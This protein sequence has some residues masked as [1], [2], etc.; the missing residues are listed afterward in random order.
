MSE[1]QKSYMWMGGDVRRQ[2]MSEGRRPWAE[3]LPLYNAARSRDNADE[4]PRRSA[5]DHTTTATAKTTTT[6]IYSALLGHA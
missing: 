2:Q 5:V 6:V 3:V 1:G 4:W